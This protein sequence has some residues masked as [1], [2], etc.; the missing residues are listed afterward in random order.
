MGGGN[1]AGMRAADGRYFFLLNSDAWVVGD[2]LDRL[3]AVR[4]RASRGGRR[5]PA[6]AQH[7]RDAAAL[8]ARRADALAARDRVPLHPQA[9]AALAAAEPALRRRLRPRRGARR[10]TGSSGRRC[11]SAARR[12]TRSGLFDEDFF[13]F[14]EEVDWM[15]RFRRAGWKV[16]F[17]PG[18]EVVHVGGASHGGT[19]YVENLRG[20]LRWFAKHRGPREAERVR[21]L[22]L[23]SLRLRALVLRRERRIARA[24]ASSR[25]ATHGRCSSSD[26]LPPPRVRDAVRARSR[27]G[28]R[29]RARAAQ[30][31]GDARVD[32]GARLRRVGGRLHA[33]RARSTSPSSCWR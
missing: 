22:L 14:S 19:L 21:R 8:G 33:A 32:A 26:R 4:R 6:A 5:R 7:R 24:C 1:N 29:A 13:M 12:S 20:H 15:T 3:V 27:L 9:R 11:S 2:G 23:W 10:S 18:A 30:R 17:F 28:R 25:P 16:L 31:L